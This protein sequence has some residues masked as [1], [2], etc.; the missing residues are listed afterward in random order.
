MA[1][2]LDDPDDPQA[3]VVGV[4]RTGAVRAWVGG[5]DF[6]PLQ[7]DLVTDERRIGSPTRFD[8]QAPGPGGQLR[9]G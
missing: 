6:K 1:K 4:D 5:K 8:V 3:A 9:G 7:L 2:H